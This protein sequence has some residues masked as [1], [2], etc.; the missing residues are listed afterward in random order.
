MTELNVITDASFLPCLHYSAPRLVRNIRDMRYED[1]PASLFGGE[2]VLFQGIY[3][4]G[5]RWPGTSIAV[6]G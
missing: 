3:V 4:V 5:S 1:R 6:C 2:R